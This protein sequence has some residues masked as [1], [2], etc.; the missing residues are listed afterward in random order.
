MLP[1]APRCTPT[2]HAISMEVASRKHGMPIL[3]LGIPEQND[4]PIVFSSH[5][6]Y[7]RIIKV[8]ARQKNLILDWDSH[9]G[10]Q[11]RGLKSHKML[12][13]TNNI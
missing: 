1:Q 11:R 9:C 8:E 3:I 12:L 4:L 10:N 5:R 2:E 7:V 13:L 6:W